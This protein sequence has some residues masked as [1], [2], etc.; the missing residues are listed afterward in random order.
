M[1]LMLIRHFHALNSALKAILLIQ[2]GL[3]NALPGDLLSVELKEAIHHIGSIT[4]NI[5][6][7]QD[8]L[9]TIFNQFCIGK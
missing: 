6:H 1:C 7:D 5:D 4:G 3:E 8:I 2:Q 9:G